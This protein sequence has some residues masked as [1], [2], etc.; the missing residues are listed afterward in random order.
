M[1]NSEK[2]KGYNETKAKI[3]RVLYTVLLHQLACKCFF[4]S[5]C[6]CIFKHKTQSLLQVLDGLSIFYRH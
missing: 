4:C 1:Q 6:T 3:K 5:C 2:K